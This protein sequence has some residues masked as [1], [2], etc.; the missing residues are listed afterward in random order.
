MLLSDEINL[1]EEST[2]NQAKYNQKYVVSVEE[3]LPGFTLGRAA[4]LAVMKSSQSFPKKHDSDDNMY[5]GGV[6][7][8][9]V[10]LLA[11]HHH[12]K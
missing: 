10:N 7:G 6:G 8:S 2:V 11:N 3:S 4:R 12:T 5:S 1:M 9:T